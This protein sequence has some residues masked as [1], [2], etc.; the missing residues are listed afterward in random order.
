MQQY[1]FCVTDLTNFDS[2]AGCFELTEDEAVEFG[3]EYA[4]KLLDE[5]PEIRNQGLCVVAFDQAGQ[6]C[7]IQPIDTVH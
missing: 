7:F 4:A 5:Q 1:S 2:A 3:K 6:A